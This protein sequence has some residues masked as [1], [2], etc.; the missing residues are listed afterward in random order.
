M[1]DL[2]SLYHQL[3][4]D[5]SRSPRN[6][7]EMPDA[8]REA[9]GLNTLCGDQLHVWLK[10]D[11]DGR[12]GDV[13][14]VGKGCAISQASASI[15]TTT[16]KGKRPEEA[17]VLFQQFHDLVTGKMPSDD[18]AGLPARLGAFAGVARFPIR[19]KCASLSW[20]ALR[21]ALRNEGRPASTE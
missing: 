19:V 13:S 7:R 9:E 6:H 4:L 8:D 21:S 17:E 16:V 14:F 1:S 20:H 10:M 18:V 15:M 12:I 3:I 5:H 11:G 2:E